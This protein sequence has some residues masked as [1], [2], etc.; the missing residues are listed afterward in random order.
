[1][2]CCVESYPGGDGLGP[3]PCP[4]PGVER[5]P[6]ETLSEEAPGFLFLVSR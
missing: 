2:A 1:M 3:G 4:G 6:D 5:D